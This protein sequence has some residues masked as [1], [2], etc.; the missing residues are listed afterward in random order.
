MNDWTLAEHTHR[1]IDDSP[2]ADP[3]LLARKVA[4]SIPDEHLR[5]AVD[6]MIGGYVVGIVS[7]ARWAKTAGGGQSRDD[8][9]AP[10]APAGKNDPD[11]GQIRHDTHAAAAGVGASRWDGVATVYKR[12]LGQRVAVEDGDW[13]FFR[14]LTAADCRSAEARRR[15][16][17]ARN[18]A[19]AETFAAVADALDA[20]NC[21]TVGDLPDDVL[22]E[23]LR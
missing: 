22:E 20:H 11:P 8:S 15:D 2:I 13:K 23:L 17:A 10:P 6:E 5:Q 1:Q 9:H 18:L 4:L 16:N 7:R 14:D 21:P 3:H 12:L 19:R